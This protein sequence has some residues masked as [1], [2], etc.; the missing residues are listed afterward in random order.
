MKRILFSTIFLMIC[1]LGTVSL[2]A[3]PVVN[4]VMQGSPRSFMVNPANCNSNQS[5][6]RM[7]YGP[8]PTSNH[9]TSEGVNF[10]LGTTTYGSE[11][12]HK[13]MIRSGG[14][15]NNPTDPRGCLNGSS[16][17]LPIYP[18][19]WNS[20]EYSGS[21]YE[22]TVMRVGTHTSNSKSQKVEYYFIPDTI[23]P[24]LLVAYECILEQPGHQWL[25]P[26]GSIGNPTV[27]IQVSNA[28]SNDPLNL[29]YYPSDYIQNG[30][31]T[32][33]NNPNC[34]RNTNWPYARYFFIPDGTD[35]Q[36][37]NPNH[38]TPS[39]WY[40]GN[41]FSINNCGNTVS[42]KYV[43]VA[44]NL[45]EQ[46]KTH[47]PVKFK[48]LMRGCT[49]SAHYSYLYYTAKM[50]P[51]KISV[52]ACPEMDMVE[53]SVP[54]GFDANSYRWKRGLNKDTCMLFNPSNT[55]KARI[56]R[57]ELWPYYRCEMESETGV[58]FVYEAY[59]TLY[60][61]KPDFSYV[62][63]AGGCQHNVFFRDNS[64]NRIIS[65]AFTV[66]GVVLAP[67]D[68]M[69]DPSPVLDWFWIKAPN[70]TVR[71][72]NPNDTLVRQVIPKYKADGVTPWDSVQ[73]RLKVN[74]SQ[75]QACD[76]LDTIIWV[77]LDTANVYCPV[78]RDTIQICES[79]MVNGKYQRRIAD[80]TYTWEYDHQIV[81]VVFRDSAWNGCDSTVKMLLLI[82]KPK[83]NVTSQKDYCDDFETTLETDKHGAGYNWE[84]STGS[85]DSLLEIDRAGTYSVT[86]TDKNSGCKASGTIVIPTC[87][88]FV[89]LVNAITPSDRG[90]KSPGDPL[91]D[92]FT[93]PQ[94]KLI[95]YVEFTV[96][97]RT[98]E[99]IY[100]F[101]GDPKDL[102][103]CGT[104]GNTDKPVE[105]NQVYPYILKYK[106]L[107]G[108]S[109]VIKSTITVL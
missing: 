80:S 50:V 15:T 47:T 42:T 107:D 2:L 11:P 108:V 27:Q 106:D 53:L 81:P 12:S 29:G 93:V 61:F 9:A 31:N 28:N 22:D 70:D 57:N 25:D 100:S 71:M 66:N 82:E 33:Y 62:D 64:I 48:I 58:P 69:D 79:S 49:A 63:S 101:K 1:M 4:G 30:N 65:P 43:I 78:T 6:A 16:S 26:Y 84:W 59:T 41:S 98:G 72:G 17:Y 14:A 94:W 88:P 86:V 45:T 73:I 74:T 39:R 52:D 95:K 92:C 23:N 60:D 90:G 36:Y 38:M 44:F 37:P 32:L 99:L 40:T 96:F 68:T 18:D 75:T 54:W 97:T 5:W 21:H 35:G 105:Y 20:N 46:A 76:C 19:A 34:P 51:G 85:T 67:A 10:T 77:K 87:K 83:V 55:Y 13:L 103:W 56:P 91:N 102:K 104:K 24:V 89:N 109:K 8:A 3:Q 7:Y